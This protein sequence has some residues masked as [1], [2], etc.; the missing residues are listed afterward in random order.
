MVRVMGS[1]AIDTIGLVPL[2]PEAD[3]TA[4]VLSVTDSPGGAGGNVAH[5]LARLGVPVSLAASVGP[6]FAGSAYEATLRNAGVDLSGL[7]RTTTPTAHAYIFSETGGPRQMLFF[8]PGAS[9]RTREVEVRKADVGHFAA[10]EIPVY[11]A[12]MDACDFVTFD[13]G[14]ELFHRDIAEILACLPHVDV[15]FC[16]GKERR[17]LEAAGFRLDAFLEGRACAVV[18]TRGAEG[19]LLHEPGAKSTRIPSAG[20]REVADPTGAGDSHRAGFLFGLHHGL[21]LESCV[22]IAGVVASFTIETVG[23][24]TGLP[25]LEQVR[26]RHAESVGPWPLQTA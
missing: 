21:D 19:A 3:A 6:D 22:R 20:A 16:N 9:A 8:H 10:G 4:G 11:P 24:Q 15:L 12:H 14:Q 18:E 1:V 7:A 2:L 17:I 23:P 5:A 25:D 13:P 26:A